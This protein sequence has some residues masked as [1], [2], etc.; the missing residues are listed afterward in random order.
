VARWTGG[1]AVP[2]KLDSVRNNASEPTLGHVIMF[3][4]ASAGWLILFLINLTLFTP[5]TAWWVRA[6]FSGV[7]LLACAVFTVVLWLRLN[8]S[9]TAD[10]S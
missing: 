6:V 4:A 1:R 10:R 8:R 5:S 7:L 3:G 2:V 9:K